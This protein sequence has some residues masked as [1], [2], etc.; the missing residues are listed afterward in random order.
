MT[1]AN[2][3]NNICMNYVGA[4]VP[5]NFEKDNFC[6]EQF[7]PDTCVHKLPIIYNFALSLKHENLCGNL[8]A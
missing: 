8:Y 1:F 3:D 7:T 4:F 2:V 5:S 6:N